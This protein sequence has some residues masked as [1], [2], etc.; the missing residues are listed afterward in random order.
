MIRGK[1]SVE[2]ITKKP[3]FEC[4]LHATKTY[5]GHFFHSAISAKGDCNVFFPCLFF[6]FLSPFFLLYFI[7]ASFQSFSFAAQFSFFFRWYLL[8]C[9]ALNFPE[10]L[11]VISYWLC[12]VAVAIKI[13]P[14]YASVP[15]IKQWK[16]PR[17][18]FYSRLEL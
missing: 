16:S 2:K 3:L 13:L 15:R 18:C 1:C 11:L 9:S 10:E 6:F 14:I 4:F 12:F 8:L 17:D 5:F 7:P